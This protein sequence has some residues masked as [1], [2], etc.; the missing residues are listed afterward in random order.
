MKGL[1]AT[2]FIRPW[3]ERWFN[4][5]N[6]FKFWFTAFD[7]T[8]IMAGVLS[9]T[10]FTRGLTRRELR[11][12][13]LD[14]KRPYL[15]MNA[16]DVTE[17]ADGEDHF[18]RIFTFTDEDFR[19]KLNS[20]VSRY[21][22][23]RA[24]MA[25]SCFP[26]VFNSMT[27]RD[28]RDPSAKRARYLH[29]FDGGN[30]DNLGL[31]TAKEVIL[32]EHRK[33]KRDGSPKYSHCVVILVDADTDYPGIDRNSPDARGVVGHFADLN[34]IGTIESLMERNRETTVKEFQVGH[35]KRPEGE[36]VQNLAFWHIKF[37]DVPESEDDPAG[38]GKLVR[39][40]LQIRTD[41]KISSDDCR[42]IDKAV[43]LLV[44]PNVAALREI[45]DVL[46]S[47]NAA[48]PAQ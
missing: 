44:V 48:V 6:A 42:R 45:H 29:V 46:P 47:P 10:L 5:I 23:A 39:R 20:D 14:P 36:E 24:V 27:L 16:T 18:G 3:V 38:E 11:I 9:R 34:V 40:L 41:F 8:D 13:D 28:Y 30:A 15:L 17:N 1:L 31:E 37:S 33:T 35:L 22:L 7:R 21:S 43:S 32:R 19:A 2:N 26:V 25:S 4:P 12:R